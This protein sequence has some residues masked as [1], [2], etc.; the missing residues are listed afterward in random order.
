MKVVMIAATSRCSLERHSF[1]TPE[2]PLSKDVL[3]ELMARFWNLDAEDI[4]LEDGFQTSIT[5]DGDAAFLQGEIEHYT[6][7]V[8]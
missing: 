2:T 5:P 1:E 4:D 7:V 8:M 3:T 6:F